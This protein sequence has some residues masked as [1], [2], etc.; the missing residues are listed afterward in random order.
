MYQF[1]LL[2]LDEIRA[3]CQLFEEEF[4]EVFLISPRDY[5]DIAG[6]NWRNWTDN[7]IEE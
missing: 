6:N 2:H 4:M 3:F 7:V 5:F 1:L